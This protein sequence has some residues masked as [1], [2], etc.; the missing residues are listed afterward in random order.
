MNVKRCE[1]SDAPIEFI[2]QLAGNYFFSSPSFA[3]LWN[4]M[5]GR[6]VCW[7]AEERGSVLAVLPGVEFGRGSL[8]R[9]QA[10]PNGCYG[11]ILFAVGEASR[12]SEIAASM[13]GRIIAERYVKAFITDFHKTIL[14]S[15][16][17]EIEEYTVFMVDISSM[18]WEPPDSK[19]RQQIHKAQREGLQMEQ[20]EASRHMND[21]M[22]L[23]GLHEKRRNTKSRYNRNFFEAL[24]EL[25]VR[26]ERVQWVWCEHE[27]RPAAS[28]IFFREGDSI[29]HWQMYYDEGLSYL[30]ATKL[31]PYQIAKEARKLGITNLNLG[32]SPPE[33]EGAEFYKSKWGGEPYVYNCYFH[34]NLLGKLW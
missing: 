9:F 34:K 11:R 13:V 2:D 8:R 1:F 29:I 10:M 6:P 25:S 26:D 32:A 18:D 17:F 30:Q 7:L 12:Q 19:L 33:A 27:G 24:A 15:G 5:H 4:S 16:G 20:F 21:F 3:K 31:I 23:V 28:S 22:N 14:N